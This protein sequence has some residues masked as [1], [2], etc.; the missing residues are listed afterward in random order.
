V[1]EVDA[2]YYALPSPENARAWVERTPG[3]FSFG[4]K[5]YAALTHHP[6]EPARLP[7][8]LQRQLGHELRAK[9][10]VYPRDLPPPLL[11]EV[12]RRF[13]AALAPLRDAGKLGYVL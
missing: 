8:D 13:G 2:T 5:A 1:V 6:I 7:A 12:W 9:R 4:V 10:S 3:S 11:D